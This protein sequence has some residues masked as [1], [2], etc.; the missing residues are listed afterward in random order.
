M[1]LP[2]NPPYPPMEAF[3]KIPSGESL[4]YQPKL[5]GFRRLAF[6]DSDNLELQFHGH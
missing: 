3:D 6:K 2:I 5:N 1:A 4:R